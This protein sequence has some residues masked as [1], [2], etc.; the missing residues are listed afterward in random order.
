[1]VRTL[2]LRAAAL[3]LAFAAG[4]ALAQDV[5]I[6]ASNPGSLYHSTGT[7]IAKMANDAAQLQGDRSSFRE[8]DGLP[9]GSKRGRLRIRDLERRGAA[10]RRDRR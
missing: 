9:P 7:A 2:H 6:A 5:G 10:R 1:M 3:S 8:R 4:S